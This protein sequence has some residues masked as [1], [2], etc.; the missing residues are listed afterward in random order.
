MSGVGR[1]ILVHCVICITVV[2][3]NNHLV[4]ILL[5]RLHNLRNALVNSLHSLHDCIVDT[6]VANHITISEV[7]A[8]KVVLLLIESIN[9]LISNL[10]SAHLGLEVVSCNLGRSNE[11]T[12]L[13]IELLLTA[14]IQEEGNV[15]VLLGLGDAQLL[16][17]ERRN[18]LT[19][20][21]IYVLLIE[22]DVQ[23]LEV[24]IV[25][26]HTAVVERQS[27]H[28][29]CRHILLCQRNGNLARAI[30]TIIKE[31]NHIVSLDLTLGIA[32]LVYANDRL[33][34]LIGHTLVVR[35]LHSC[36]H[37]GCVLTDTIHEQVI[38]NLH[39]LPALIAIHSV[40][41]TYDRSDLTGR[42]RHVSLQSLDK[43]LT[44]LRVGVTT[45]HKAV[46]VSI[47]DAV[48]LRNVAKLVEVL[49]R[50][51]HTTVRHKTHKVYV[52]AVSLRI[53][54]S[55]H[56]L[57]ILQNRVVGASA[58]NLHEVLVNHTTCS[59]IE[60]TYLRVT[61]L[62]VGQTYVL[63]ISAEERV[64][65]LLGHRRDILGVYRVDY[66]RSGVITLAPAVKN[67]Q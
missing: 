26:S 33:H 43:A 65:I 59:D 25:R 28:T 39:T 47:L 11:D 21:V 67:H 34:E 35:A 49:D 5:C 56:N 52:H 17:T 16:Q 37:I 30:I 23:T 32:I 54:E 53:L 66:V 38:T 55:C 9:Q 50:R 64:G 8:D 58:V 51:V 3:N 2:C 1:A 31:D 4:A 19:D 36:N 18:V 60:V 48:V 46:N 62:T 10:V 61:H 7:Q 42:L 63:A 15:S 22:E 57:G 40:V 24:C 20:S 12:I 14:T 45:I 44:A 29:L 27:V 13:T 41:A 6:G